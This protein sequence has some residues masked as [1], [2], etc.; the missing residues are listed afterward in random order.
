MKLNNSFPKSVLTKIFFIKVRLCNPDVCRIG[1][2]SPRTVSLRSQPA[3]SFENIKIEVILFMFVGEIYVKKVFICSLK[4]GII[5]PF[6][7]SLLTNM[8]TR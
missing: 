5:L 7:D 8:E 4:G 3:G 2:V 1:K 6:I